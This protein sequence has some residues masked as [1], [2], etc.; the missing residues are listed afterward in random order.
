[1]EK[2]TKSIPLFPQHKKICFFFNRHF[3]KEFL[4]AHLFLVLE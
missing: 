3:Y 4:E 2:N 1:M